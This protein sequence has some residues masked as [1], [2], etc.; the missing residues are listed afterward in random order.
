MKFGCEV[1][2]VCCGV[3]CG[4]L[5]CN[6]VV[7]CVMCCV[8]GTPCRELTPAECDNEFLMIAKDL[9]RYGKHLFKAKVTEHL[10]SNCLI[11]AMHSHHM[12]IPPHHTWRA[13]VKC[14]G[15]VPVCSSG[16]L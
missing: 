2:C 13:P 6:V 11:C 15:P 4:V 9:P 1:V 16:P 10:S 5:Y 14:Y 7:W 12:C 8:A 3:S